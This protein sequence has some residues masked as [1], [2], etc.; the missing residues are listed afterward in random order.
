MNTMEK[1][2]KII[3]RQL[4]SAFAA[5]AAGLYIIGTGATA[6]ALPEGGQV[7]AGQAAITTAGSTM[8]IAQQTAQAIINWQNF[9]IGSGEAVHI[10]QPNSQAILL[11]RVIGSNPSEI[12]GQLTANGQVILVNPNGVFFRPGSSV[13]VG[14][15]T[16]STLNIANED[17]LKGQLRFAGDS[18][19]PVINAGS[20]TAQNGY[21]NLLAKEVVNEGIIAAQTGSVNLAAGSG[22]SLDYN[23]D[24]KMTVAVTDGAYQSAV[25]NK[26]LIRADGGLVVMTASGKDA[27]M[28]SAVNNSGMIQANTLGEATG[29]ISLTGDNIA[30][31]GTI[32]ADGGSN[33]QG[34]TIKI[35]ANHKT[36]V[37]GQLSA[38][39]G[40]LAGDGGF[41]ETSGD[42]VSI[43]EH[44]S[45]QANA[46]QGKA[47][48]WLLDPVDITISDDGTDYGEDGT[49]I[50]TQFINNT[51]RYN[52]VTITTNSDDNGDDG[53]ITVDGEIIVNP[54]TGVTLTLEA[55]KAI[56]INKDISFIGNNASNLT[57]K[58]TDADSQ[59]NNQAKIDIG[60]GTL[61][62]TT[63]KNGVLNAGSIGADTVKITA[64]TIK[65]AEM[66]TPPVAINQL[67]LRQANENK[68]IYIGA[69]SSNS[70]GAESMAEASLFASGGVF[71]QVG[72]LKLNAGRNQDIHL[73]DVDFQDAN[74]IAI[75]DKYN[76]GRT[77][78]IAGKVSTKGSLEVETEKFNVADNARLT[79]SSLQMD[80]DVNIIRAGSN[81]KIISTNNEAFTYNP[82]DF[83]LQI[84]N[85]T[86]LTR[87]YSINYD[88][89][90]ALEGFSKY[91]VGDNNKHLTMEG[92][93]LN[94]SITFKGLDITLANGS[95]QMQ[96]KG[97]LNLI[98]SNEIQL[99]DIKLNMG[100][101]NLN[102]MAQNLKVADS[103]V[104]G[105]GN[106]YLNTAV[107][108]GSQPIILGS[109]GGGDYTLYIKPEYFR[110]GGLFSN[111]KGR[112]Y[113]GLLPDDTITNAP[114][115]LTS[116]T[117]IQN[118]LYLATQADIKGQPG[119]S[120]DTNG[121]NLY[122]ISK[123]GNIGL[124]YTSLYNTPIKQAVARGSVNLN[125]PMNELGTITNVSGPNGVDIFS[126]G[127]ITIGRTSDSGI[128]ASKGYI[129]ITS[130]GS[131]VEFGDYANLTADTVLIFAQD[132]DNGAFKNYAKNNPFSSGTKWG[133]ATYDALKDD[134]GKLTG[135]F[136]QYG[137]T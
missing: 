96:G 109:T 119:S 91:E 61:N 49:K 51:L 4:K 35:I 72:N 131:S 50:N 23:G 34:G 122:L 20:L 15:L 104:S 121:N 83:D 66:V 6:Y 85:N 127:K 106:L 57:L 78:N 31:T 56:N 59:I 44:S 68:G 16:A 43:G 95:I 112:V 129:T 90:N 114:I 36:A 84:V 115:R 12:F 27:L 79:S 107:T 124:T 30:T 29:Q 105:T 26:K 40:Q 46:P 64:N 81:A 32:S 13:D 99:Y 3:S 67:E 111:L 55:N 120:L 116:G 69:T 47:G 135:A 87:D 132:R 62:I 63:G 65:Q 25:A 113:I 74:I 37:D 38:Q 17:F 117:N 42:I 101:A 28:D 1:K 22:M 128:T 14:G 11:N 98:A 130:G 89:L 71:S 2:N 88:F 19:N 41:I 21:V 33:G 137:K 8:T 73:Q 82:G 48:Q 118:E 100:E 52:N 80:E 126:N 75:Q 97:T 54:S 102:M 77:L 108:N 58:T 134:Y 70:T 76:S 86:Y 94:K 18:Q 103:Q 10:N 110:S 60:N 133:I 39:G 7:A 92:G 24:G 5:W 136:R 93:Q 53:T 45:I 125:N 123:S 9:G